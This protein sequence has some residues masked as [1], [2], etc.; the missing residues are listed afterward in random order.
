MIDRLLVAAYDARISPILCFT[1]ADLATPDKLSAEYASLRVP[2]VVTQPGEPLDQAHDLLRGHWTVLVGHSGVGNST[3]INALVPGANRKTGD[4]N[5]VT[6][7]GRHT[8]TSAVAL[9]LP[10]ADGWVIDTP[11]VRS[12]GLSQVSPDSVLGA[13]TDLEPYVAE[14]PRGCDHAAG[15]LDCA[16]DAAVADGKLDSS[17]LTSLRR[18]LAAITEPEY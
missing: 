12:F 11:G 7:R 9:P 13:F 6:G 1:K 17:R 18:I 10:G 16:L 15:A 8:S 4:V 14:C 5:D 3:R 2:I